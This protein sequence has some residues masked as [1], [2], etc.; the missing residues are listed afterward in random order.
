MTPLFNP[1][2]GFLTLL[3]TP[4]LG[5]SRGE[6]KMTTLPEKLLLLRNERGLSQEKAAA[7]QG[8]AYRSYRRYETGEREPTA[9][10]LIRMA[11]FYGVTIDY[12]V[13]RTEKRS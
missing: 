8:I 6:Q 9:S 13:G 4:R 1:K 5:L 11:D 12:L 10:V 7:S 2:R 3:Y